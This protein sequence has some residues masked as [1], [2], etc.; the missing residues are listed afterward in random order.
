MFIYSRRI[1]LIASIALISVAFVGLFSKPLSGHWALGKFL[2]LNALI[3]S[4]AWRLAQLLGDTRYWENQVLDVGVVALALIVIIEVALGTFGWLHLNMLMLGVGLVSLA[5]WCLPPKERVRLS[6][7][8]MPS[9]R[10]RLSFKPMWAWGVLIGLVLFEVAQV[11]WAKWLTPPMDD[12]LGYH[13]PFSVE[14][15]QNHNLAMPVPPAGDPSTPFYPLNSSLW[16][17]WLMM[18]FQSDVLVRFAQ[19]PFA[20]LMLVSIARLGQNMGLTREISWASAFLVISLPD[21]ARHTM[22]VENDLILAALLVVATTNVAQLWSRPDLR[23]L[24]VGA[25]ALGLALGTKVLALPYVAVLSFIYIVAIAKG[26][27]QRGWKRI[28]QYWILTVGLILILGGYSYLRNHVVMSNPFYPVIIRFGNQELL[29]GLYSVTTEWK[30]HHPYYPFDWLAFLFDSHTEFGWT[31]PLWILPGLGLSGWQLIQERHFGSTIMFAW[32]LLGLAIFWY[33]LPYHFVRY[34]YAVLG[35]AI[36]LATWGWQKAIARQKV[37]VVTLALVAIN[38][39]SIP[40]F[41]SPWQSPEYW[42]VAVIVVLV[43]SCL[44]LIG[45]RSPQATIRKAIL[46]G[47]ATILICLNILW[48]SYVDLYKAHRFEQWQRQSRFLGTQ[49]VAWEYLATETLRLSATIAIVGT[50]VIFPLYGATLENRIVYIM[51]DGHLTGYDWGRPYRP[52]GPP[53]YDAWLTALAAEG[54]KYVYVTPNVVTGG[55][56]LEDKWAA[57]RT[58]IFALVFW[59]ESVHIWQTR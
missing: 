10:G 45:R 33:I 1:I 29:P 26:W 30:V 52:E 27:Q 23:R 9:E 57:D 5:V 18:P 38:A 37:V 53:N 16:M 7:D 54:V 40:K 14:W 55:W 2:V 20:I 49:P 44:M 17:T 8:Q 41:T 31:I 58:D 56:P 4:V 50:N 12:A 25:V 39:V 21:I 42:I 34:L 19:M 47:I 43:S 59:N 48:P 32:I 22:V 11:L 28:G 6:D 24:A 36:V 35:W 46:G 13:L 3:I 15:M 51:P